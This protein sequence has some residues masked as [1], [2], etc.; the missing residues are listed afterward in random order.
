MDPSP[1]ITPPSDA[2]HVMLALPLRCK[3][4]PATSLCRLRGRR[5]TGYEQDHSIPSWCGVDLSHARGHNVQSA[6]RSSTLPPSARPVHSYAPASS[7]LGNYAVDEPY[8]RTP[9][10][11]L[12]SLM[13]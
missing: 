4:A 2:C 11:L 3:K 1:L 9:I 8:G 13:A 12:C 7:S 6:V 10:H 5:P